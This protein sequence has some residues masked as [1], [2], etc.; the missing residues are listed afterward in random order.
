[1][2][3]VTCGLSQNLAKKTVTAVKKWREGKEEKYRKDYRQKQLTTDSQA[4]QA[5]EASIVKNKEKIAVKSEGQ[6]TLI[7]TNYSGEYIN[8]EENDYSWV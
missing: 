6:V 5:L 8:I 4:L 2:E 1:M 7:D 3:G